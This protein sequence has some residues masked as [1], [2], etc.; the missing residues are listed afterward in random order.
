[1]LV[2]PEVNPMLKL[3]RSALNEVDLE[4]LR[5]FVGPGSYFFASNEHYRLLAHLSGL[6]PGKTLFDIGTHRG[7]SALAL[8]HAGNPVE[9]F[10]IV[11]NIG[12]RE[13]PANVHYNLEDLFDLTVREKWK[14]KLLGSPIILIDVDPHEGTREYEM[15][16]WLQKNKYR[17]AVVLDD[18]R[19]FPA[20]QDNLWSRIDPRHKTDVTALGHWSGTGIVSF[21]HRVE[22]E[23]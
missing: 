22:V 19:H 16:Q 9:S 4:P 17:G 3:S 18:I 10:D 21:T 8:S 12:A 11:D 23:Q 15:V 2:S 14:T 20:M 13:R 6:Y 1:M 5:R 7:D